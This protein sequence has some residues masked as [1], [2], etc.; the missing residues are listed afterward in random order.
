[1]KVADLAWALVV[2]AAG[3]VVLAVVA[4]VLFITSI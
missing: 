1:M 3:L 4:A 2:V